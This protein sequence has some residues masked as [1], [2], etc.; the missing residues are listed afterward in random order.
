MRWGQGRS[1]PRPVALGPVRVYHPPAFL[2]P[3]VHLG[4][5]PERSDR[6]GVL[7]QQVRQ[8]S[9]FARYL[10]LRGEDLVAV[11]QG[12]TTEPLVEFLRRRQSIE[13]LLH[14]GVEIGDLGICDRQLRA[15]IPLEPSV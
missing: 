5:V 6:P 14:H 13:S 1:W 8:D 2:L 9:Y 12:S 11:E 4:C 7:R 3:L 15:G 10:Y